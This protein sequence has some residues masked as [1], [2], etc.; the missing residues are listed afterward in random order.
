MKQ[1]LRYASL[2]VLMVCCAIYALSNVS[3]A[4]DTPSVDSIGKEVTDSSKHSVRGGDGEVIITWH[5]I[6]KTLYEVELCSPKLKE[7]IAKFIESE[8]E[9][10]AKFDELFI[11]ESPYFELYLDSTKVLVQTR[12]SR[13]GGGV[14]FGY[15]PERYNFDWILGYAKIGSRIALVSKIT[16][17]SIW[18]TKVSKDAPF[19]TC[20]NENPIEIGF[21]WYTGTYNGPGIYVFSDIDDRGWCG[22][23]I[24]PEDYK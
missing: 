24:S 14:D 21:D 1:I 18:S 8:A 22:F 3:V 2:L 17:D 11:V 23:R 13:E 20:T 16:Y 5:H 6:T 7:D 12:L 15:W 19:V 9:F 4:V 10:E